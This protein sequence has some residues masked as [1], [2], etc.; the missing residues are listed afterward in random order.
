MKVSC[1]IYISMINY[2]RNFILQGI[3]TLTNNKS[4]YLD[5]INEEL[6]ILFRKTSSVELEKVKGSKWRVDYYSLDIDYKK[7]WRQV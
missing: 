7:E 5:P 1:I 6:R 2:K 3:Y 4:I